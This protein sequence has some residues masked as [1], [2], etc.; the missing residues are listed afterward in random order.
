MSE[1]QSQQSTSDSRLVSPMFLLA[2]A[3]LLIAG[4]LVRSMYL[5]HFPM[6]VHNDES[7]M[8][9]YGFSPFY[10]PQGAWALYG[11]SFAGHPNFGY[12]LAAIPSRLLGAQSLWN[13]RISSSIMGVISILF[14]AYF[15]KQSY[16]KRMALL[17][18]MFVT[19]F[20]LH[21]HYS[22]TGFHYIHA[23]MFFGITSAAFFHT[24]TTGSKR[25]A[26]VTGVTMGLGALVYPATNVL[27]FAMIAAGLV[28]K[29]PTHGQSLSIWRSPRTSLAACLAFAGGVALTFGPQALYSISHGFLNRLEHTYILHPHSIRH[30]APLMG[31][32]P[33]TTPGVL[34]YN[35]LKTFE[36]F[37]WRDSGEQYNFFQNPLPIWAGI[38]AAIGFLALTLRALKR[39]PIAI[40]LA[41]TCLGTVLASALMV[42][43]NFSP[44]LILFSILLPLLCA[45]GLHTLFKLFRV[46]PLPLVGGISVAIL[47]GWSTWNWHYYNRAVDPLR[48]RLSDTETWLF[49]IPINPFEVKQIVNVSGRDLNLVESNFRLVF[50]SAKPLRVEAG[51]IDFAAE[52]VTSGQLPAIVIVN[53]AQSAE[54]QSK[55]GAKGRTVQTFSY[56][57]QAVSFVYVQ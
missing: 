11:S 54:T 18:L 16:G 31:N 2:C 53:N 52:Q 10:S 44:H 15:I 46:T 41:S 56:P 47:V 39:E 4:A 22:R 37:Y 43:A 32:I 40:Y 57:R 42:E 24:I 26:F 1:G 13:L 36:F 30:V 19:P 34:W 29:F 17:F 27:P 6:Q 55:L 8:V 7:A 3:A 48:P 33:V 21:V 45:L 51:N 14:F 9:I 23:A 12:W 49:N 35:L 28:G 20:H 5:T 25:W 38:L 50:P